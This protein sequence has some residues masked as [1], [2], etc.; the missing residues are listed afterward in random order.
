MEKV[1]FSQ[2]SNFKFNQDELFFDIDD[3]NLEIA[4][5]IFKQFGVIVLK[6]KNKNEKSQKAFET[7]YEKFSNSREIDK[8]NG[9]NF[10]LDKEIDSNIIAVEKHPNLLR[11]A[12]EIIKNDF[13]DPPVEP[14]IFGSKLLVKDSKFQG[15]IFLH[16]DSCYQLGGKKVT[17][18]F[19]FSDLQ[20]EPLKSSCIRILVGTHKF[21]HLG[22]AGQISRDVLEDEW[23]EFEASVDKNDYILMDPHCWHYSLS[24]DLENNFRAIYTFTFLENGPLAQ[25]LPGENRIINSNKFTSNQ[26]FTRSRVSRIKELQSII[27]KVGV[28]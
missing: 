18:F 9:V 19:T 2:I 22:D 12:S 6:N 5:K 11:I 8:F 7:M 3:F 23:P 27:D 14:A 4:K 24:S 26:I 16:Q 10:C 15:E 13:D 28:A 20:K 21:G 17:V 25:R 1:S